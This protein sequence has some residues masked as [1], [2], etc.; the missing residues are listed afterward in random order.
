M[1]SLAGVKFS[2]S[3]VDLLKR[4]CHVLEPFYQATLQLSNDG[5][6]ISE[7]LLWD[8]TL[9]EISGLKTR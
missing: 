6:C 9:N 2:Q 1:K 8:I 3:Q 7:V 5:S 4:V